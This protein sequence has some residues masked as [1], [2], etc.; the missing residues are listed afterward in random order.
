MKKKNNFNKKNFIILI[1]TSIIF[2]FPSVCFSNIE[3]DITN[4]I[5]KCS[6]CHTLTGNSL[7][8]AWPKIAEQH[9]DYLL[10]QMIEYKKGK[11]GNRF[12]PTMFGMLQGLNEEDMKDLAEY[13]SKQTLE[14]SN[15]KINDLD[16]TA[17]KILYLYGDKKNNIT[18]CVGCHSIDG[19]GNKLANFPN[20]KWQHKE[21]IITQ[22]KKFKTHDR[23]NDINSIMRDITEA[24]TNEQMD[25]LATYISCID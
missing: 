4:K 22:L 11:N 13:F 10:K 6:A 16:F 21:Y 1:L 19:T 18:A 9:S 12:D 8:P 24:M 14:K 2:L 23:S 5:K 7:I 20:L 25:A 15:L 17:G 3:N